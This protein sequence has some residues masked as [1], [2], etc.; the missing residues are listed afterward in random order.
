MIR[1]LIVVF[2]LLLSTANV[3]TSL[4][5]LC[6]IPELSSL[7]DHSSLITGTDTEIFIVACDPHSSMYPEFLRYRYVDV[8]MD[9]FDEIL[10]HSSDFM[11]H[12]EKKF[13]SC[14]EHLTKVTTYS[15]FF[16]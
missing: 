12:T 8:D 7:Q 9:V 11:K 16:Y 1:M 13:Y 4:G 2:T 15:M 10:H 14:C 5:Y 3:L 6:C